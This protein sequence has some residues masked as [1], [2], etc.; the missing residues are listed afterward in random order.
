[1]YIL[2]Y[3]NIC[4][5]LNT[6]KRQVWWKDNIIKRGALECWSFNT[7]LARDSSQK[8]WWLWI[9]RKL[10]I[11]PER[12]LIAAEAIR[13]RTS[14]KEGALRISSRADKLSEKKGN[15]KL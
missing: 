13:N 12:L 9:E 7:S 15:Q 8:Y 5:K 11:G 2:L 3:T 1:M 4:I 14:C 10:R 6:Y